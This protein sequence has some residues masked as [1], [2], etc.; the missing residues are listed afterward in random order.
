VTL[1]IMIENGQLLFGKQKGAAFLSILRLR[2]SVSDNPVIRRS[3][4]MGWPY[5][6][7]TGGCS[8]N[9]LWMMRTARHRYISTECNFREIMFPCLSL[10][11]EGGLWRR[12]IRKWA[13]SIGALS[14]G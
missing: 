14:P 7:I 9:S 4:L 6:I 2:I 8:G 3:V 13:I 5:S 12:F 11:I 10:S 1:S